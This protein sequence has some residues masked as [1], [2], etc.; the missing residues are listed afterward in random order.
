MEKGRAPRST[1][2]RRSRGVFEMLSPEFEIL[3]RARGPE[4]FAGIV[5]VY[6]LTAGLPKNWLCRTIAAA[7]KTYAPFLEDPIPQEIRG[8]KQTDAA[9]GSR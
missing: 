5:P 4:S 9:R 1:A 3:K 6:P 7:V 2:F 8:K